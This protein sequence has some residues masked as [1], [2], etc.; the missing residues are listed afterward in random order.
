VLDGRTMIMAG[1]TRQKFVAYPIRAA[2]DGRQT[3]NFVAE[4]R[5]DGG[6]LAEREDWSKP[7]RLDDFLPAFADWSF[8]W[9]DV[10][11]LIRGAGEVWV[12]PMIDRDPLPR[13]STGPVTLLGDAAHPM[14]PIG[15]NGASQAILDAEALA[16]ALASHADV[17]D[18]LEAYQSARLPPTSQLVLDNRQTGPERVLQM[19]KER[20]DGRCA[21][22]H[23]CVP[24]EELAAV[25]QRYKRLAG[26]D[27]DTVNRRAGAS[28]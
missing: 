27:K 16:D 9:L 3:I 14:Y 22:V 23:T 12:Y 15:S 25:A 24:P 7:G 1:H 18:A 13:W 6:S 10:P 5:G 28:A 19:V 20:C 21:D 17:R 26:F 2:R 8:G 4:L 11:A